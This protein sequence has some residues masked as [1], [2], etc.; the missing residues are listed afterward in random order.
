M[1]KKIPLRSYTQRVTESYRAG[2]SKMLLQRCVY[3]FSMQA[4]CSTRCKSGKWYM[5]LSTCSW[6]H[7]VECGLMQFAKR[8]LVIL[9]QSVYRASFS[10][11]NCNTLRLHWL[12]N[13]WHAERI[14]RLVRTVHLLSIHCNTLC[15]L[16]RAG[17]WSCRINCKLQ[18]HRAHPAVIAGP[19]V[20][21]DY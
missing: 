6:V 5:Q 8:S 19:N 10:I 21:A 18:I 2:N 13:R 11:E 20:V 4:G 3:D 15:K 12:A 17:S 14:R 9:V 16:V 1:R 7:A